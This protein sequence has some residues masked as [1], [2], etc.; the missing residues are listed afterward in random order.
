MKIDKTTPVP[1]FYQL[2]NIILSEIKNGQY[3]VGDVLPTEAE[4]TEKY[5][6]S[7]TTVRQA[8]TELVQDGWLHRMKGKGTFVSQPKI[9]HQTFIKKIES[10]NEQIKRLGMVPSTE[11]LELTKISANKEIAD[12]LQISEGDDVVYLFRKRM[13]NH[14]PIVTIQTFLPYKYCLN[15]FNYDLNE[16]R[17]YEILSQNANTKIYRIKRKIEAVEA[18]KEDA[19]LLGIKQGKPIQ[20]FISTGYNAFDQPIEYSLARYIGSRNTFEVT[21]FP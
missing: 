8:M 6:I 12:I 16:K 15:L 11:V 14:E 3:K 21:V 13:A 2:K 4:L 20:F 19:Q 9:Q 5:E 1:L 7:R 18:T 10:F 17:L